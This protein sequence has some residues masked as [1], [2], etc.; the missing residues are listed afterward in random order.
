MCKDGVNHYGSLCTELYERLHARAPEDELAFYLS[1][2]RPG[3]RIL[4]PLCGSGRFLVPFLE[5]GL[6]IRG[7]DAS[8]EMLSRLREK[9]PRAR[10]ERADLAAYSPGERFDYIFISS[11]SVSLFTDLELCKGILRR[12]RGL[13]APDGVFVFAVDTVAARCPDDKEY[14]LAVSVPAGDGPELRLRTKN[15]YDPASQTQFSPGIYERYR[16]AALLEQETMDFQTH[17]YRYGEMEGYLAE[18]G[19]SRVTTYATFTKE[20]AVDDRCEMFLFECAADG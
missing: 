2:A 17:L 14:R 12:I 13:L 8:E 19:F 5:R 7:M 10:V 3:Q 15:H 20:P 6:D 18:A 1:Y 4:E 11:G 9:A 16:G